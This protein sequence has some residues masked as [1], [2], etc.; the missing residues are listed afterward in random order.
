MWFSQMNRENTLFSLLFDMIERISC[1][2]VEQNELL[3]SGNL[4]D[5]DTRFTENYL[6]ILRRRKRIVMSEINNQIIGGNNE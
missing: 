2:I 5:K 6:D 4:D 1:Q 3:I